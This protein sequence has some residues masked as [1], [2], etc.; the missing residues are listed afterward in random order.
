[1]LQE[2]ISVCLV[3]DQKALAHVVGD[4]RKLLLLP[5][6]LGKLLPDGLLLLVDPGEKRRD[7]I[8]GVVH[9]RIIEVQFV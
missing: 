2:R 4:N 6:C 7:L 5:F 8:V 3:D 1:M 9:L